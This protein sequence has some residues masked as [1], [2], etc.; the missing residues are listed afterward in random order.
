VSKFSHSYVDVA[1]LR[2]HEATGFFVPDLGLEGHRCSQ[3]LGTWYRLLG[4]PAPLTQ[5]SA[6]LKCLVGVPVHNS[7][8]DKY[9]G[10]VISRQ[11][12]S[13]YK[14]PNTEWSYQLYV[15]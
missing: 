11:D 8:A 4:H 3:L 10:S 6:C 7:Q 15:K 9:C 12:A 2:M 5:G 14:L 1:A 13:P